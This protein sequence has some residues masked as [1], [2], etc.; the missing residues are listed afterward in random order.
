MGTLGTAL[1]AGPSTTDWITAISTLGLAV[2]TIALVMVTAVTVISAQRSFNADRKDAAEDR[3][4]TM[5]SINTTEKTIGAQ[6]LASYRPML[7]E[8]SPTGPV[9]PDMGARSTDSDPLI[10]LEMGTFKVEIDPREVYVRINNGF[11]ILSIP[12]RNVGAGLAVIDQEWV[13]ISGPEIKAVARPIV[14]RPRIPVGET[15]RIDFEA[16]YEPA[17]IVPAVAEWAIW[18]EYRDHRG[19]QP[20]LAIVQVGQEDPHKGV[21]HVADIVFSENS[22]EEF[23]EELNKSPQADSPQRPQ[24]GA[25]KAHHG[26]PASW[27]AVSIIIIG[28]IVGGI[29]I[30]IGPTWC[31]FWL[32]AGIVAIGSMFALS[33]GILDDWY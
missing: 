20:T 29:A 6:I 1:L 8:V 9:F 19:L 15:T 30:V 17:E 26:R 16:Q 27:V 5:E 24:D 31:L 7:I 3:R 21:W 23:F 10:T 25:L 13:R 32:A 12:L 2:F 22:Y 4:L 11:A 33:V 18:V 28:F 14:H